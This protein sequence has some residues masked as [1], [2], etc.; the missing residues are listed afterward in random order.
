MFVAKLHFFPEYNHSQ[1]KFFIENLVYIINL[2][3][4][5]PET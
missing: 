2:I 3:K 4:F 5:A 1:I